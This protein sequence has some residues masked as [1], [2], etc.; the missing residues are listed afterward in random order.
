[1]RNRT[2]WVLSGALS[3]AVL[4]SVLFF[5]LGTAFAV[6][7]STG[8]TIIGWND[9]GMHCMDKDF[10]VFSL[11][12]PF[13]NIRA[14]VVNPSGK[15]VKDPT[16]LTI[17]YEPVKDPAG[18]I[19]STSIGKTNFWTYAGSLFNLNSTLA[20]NMGLAGFAMP[21]T[22]TT[23]K[24]MVFETSFNGWSATGI[25]I[26]PIADGGA[27]STYP[28]MKLSV[29][30]SANTLLASTSIVLPVSSEM[31]CKLC[32][33]AD[34]VSTA[35]RP[36]AGWVYPAT[37]SDLDVDKAVRLN[38]LRLHD[39]HNRTNPLD[40]NSAFTAL[41]TEALNA[42][43]YTT[44]GLYASAT[45]GKPVL[46]AACHGSNA[47]GTTSYSTIPALTSSVHTKHAGVFDPIS[48]TTMN[49]STNRDS[50]YR[51]HPG[52]ATKCL[53]GAMGSA[54]ASNGSMSM[55]CQGCHGNM[56]SVGNPARTGWLDQPNCQNCHTGTATN[57]SGQIRYTSAFDST[58]ARR[59]AAD[60]IFATNPNQPA[61]PYSL[62]R[63]SSGHGGLQCEA[64][65]GA[66]HA[67]YPSSH[68]ND[69]VQSIALQGHAGVIAECTACH[70]TVPA[71]ITGGPHGT[72]PV[73]QDWVNTHHDA[74]SKVGVATCQKCHGGDNKGTELARTYGA[75][76]Y[77]TK[78]GTLKY[79][80]GFQIG[81][82]TCHN[83]P[84]SSNTTLNKAPVVS[85][86][87][88]TTTA[89]TSISI[90][91]TATDANGNVLTL[92][93]VSQTTHG[94][95]GINGKTAS[96]FPDP[97][98]KGTDTFTFAAWDGYTNSNLGTVTITIK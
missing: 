24:P 44:N 21:G 18:L 91:L 78:W 66:T 65:H 50:C 59:T 71:T 96:Y 64:C 17:T 39:D 27:V 70:V 73:G 88:A 32:H 82:Y 33:A 67:E 54:V 58:G 48:N 69:N 34:S 16:G 15:L 86:T 52:S 93:V 53:R 85:N 63:F 7:S 5:P 29:R 43:G 81:C 41:Y 75:R 28:M 46:C 13:N 92:R 23:R 10:S 62:F 90:P 12:P 19:N 60:P 55:Q 8:W 76:S 6:A 49:D 84:N 35:A 56:A 11:L 40:V 38:V 47:L 42:K 89:G 83:G 4:A 9:L 36:L 57:N 61:A 14:Q 74:V 72:H 94:N 80:K 97:G 51:C 31:S 79:W 26:T 77:S 20:A 22:T 87:T 1:M 45:G 95:T 37:N 30:N 2:W 68:T 3:I 98:Y 25:P